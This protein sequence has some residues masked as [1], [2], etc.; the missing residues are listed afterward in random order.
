M[1]WDS[2]RQVSYRTAKK[3]EKKR[4]KAIRRGALFPH[5]GRVE[6][7]RRP[8]DPRRQNSLYVTCRTFAIPGGAN[9][10]PWSGYTRAKRLCDLA[11]P[12]K[13]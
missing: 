7:Y 8:A 13:Q 6:M 3:R 5:V 1:A 12:A 9:G 2:R 4:N 11:A 10:E